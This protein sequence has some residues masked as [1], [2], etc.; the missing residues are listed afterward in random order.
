MK[1]FAG[2]IAVVTGDSGMRRELVRQLVAEACSVA[3]CD[4]SAAAA[5]AGASRIKGWVAQGPSASLWSPGL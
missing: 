3:I 4:V 2:K 5:I 1:D